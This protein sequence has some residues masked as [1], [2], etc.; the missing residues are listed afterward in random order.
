[1]RSP[2]SITAIFQQLDRYR[3]QYSPSFW[4]GV[5]VGSVALHGI[6]G[7]MLWS[8][9]SSPRSQPAPIPIEMIELGTL[10]NESASAIAAPSAP[11]QENAA[12]RSEAGNPEVGP[13][14]DRPNPTSPAAATDPTDST[15]PTDPTPTPESEPETTEDRSAEEGSEESSEE[16]SA[17]P[18]SSDPD[19]SNPDPPPP[20]SPGQAPDD[21]APGTVTPQGTL[22]G[23]PSPSTPGQVSESDSSGLPGTVVSP[24]LAPQRYQVVV[25][26]L[27]LRPESDRLYEQ[28]PILQTYDPEFLADP[29]TPSCPITPA[30]SRFFDRDGMGLGVV[31]RITIDR[32]GQIV[33]LR[34]D[35]TASLVADPEYL[36]FLGCLMQ[37]WQFAPAI[38]AGQPTETDDLIIEVQILP[39]A[40]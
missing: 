21:Q 31:V 7:W 25:R 12:S 2:R 22:P 32:Q 26:R 11:S 6:A 3:A 15:D 28:L 1:M 18:D 38:V 4:V 27:E 40:P 36:E 29:R 10:D 35:E 20:D 17:D 9:A 33:G 30:V 8:R 39:I 5:G 34:A 13:S 23:V 16:S 24:T 14:S 19:P 37:S